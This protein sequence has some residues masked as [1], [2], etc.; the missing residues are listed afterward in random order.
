LLS[1]FGRSDYEQRVDS[2]RVAVG[3]DAAFDR[4]WQ[5]G[6]ALTL[7]QAIDLALD[8]TVTRP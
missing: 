4:A 1:G 5:Q 7:E 3:D 8:E 6:R 2:A